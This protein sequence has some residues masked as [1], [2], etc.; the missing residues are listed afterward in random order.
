MAHPDMT[1]HDEAADVSRHQRLDLALWVAVLLPPLAWALNVGVGLQLVRVVCVSQSRGVLVLSHLVGIAL[2]LA[3]VAVARRGAYRAV[4]ER[5]GDVRERSPFV[6]DLATGLAVMFALVMLA[7]LVYV[8]T[9][10]AC[11]P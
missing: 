8:L 2:A 5:Q 7:S 1:D 11:P 10:R 9:I 3:A 6:V 4:S